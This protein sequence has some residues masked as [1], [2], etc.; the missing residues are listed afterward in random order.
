MR[1]TS[2]VDSIKPFQQHMDGQGTW[3]ALTNQYAG[4][5]KWEAEIKKQD[6]LL[7]T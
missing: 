3:F 6:D 1:G 5:D 2:Y 7:H 4:C